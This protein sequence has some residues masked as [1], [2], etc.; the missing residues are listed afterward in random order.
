MGQQHAQGNL[1][2]AR[3]AG[4]E[5]WQEIYKRLL[6]IELA[7]VMQDHTGRGGGDDFGD[8]G[9]IVNGFSGDGRRVRCVSEMP[10]TF[11]GDQL[12]LMR[13]GNGCSGKR[14][15]RN[16]GLQNVE[17]ALKLLVLVAE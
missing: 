7:T 5:A 4:G 11:Q 8:R 9:E 14:A 10:E 12:T 16:A 6:K 2:A 17:S 13:D 3:I 15:L 1:V